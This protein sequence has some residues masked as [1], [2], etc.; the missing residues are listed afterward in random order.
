VA[1]SSRTIMVMRAANTPSEKVFNRSGVSLYGA[2]SFPSCYVLGARAA[3][4]KHVRKGANC[5][6]S[7]M[8]QFAASC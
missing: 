2:Q 1:R 7:A 8:R 5:H 6:A 3:S 4:L